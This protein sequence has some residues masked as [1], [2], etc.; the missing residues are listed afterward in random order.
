MKKF[1][2]AR[3]VSSHEPPITELSQPQ[4]Q[5]LEKQIFTKSLKRLQLKEAIQPSTMLPH[6]ELDVALRH[7]DAPK[8]QQLM[9]NQILADNQHLFPQD[10]PI[11]KTLGKKI[12]LMW[13][14]GIAN[15]HPAAPLLHSYSNVGCPVDCGEN[16][17]K[18]QIEAAI[19]RGPH[20]SAKHPIARKCLIAEAKEKEKG[21]Y[22]TIVKYGNIKHSLPPE[23]KISPIAMIP[24]KSRLFRCILDLSFVLNSRETSAN[25]VNATTTKLAPQKSMAE[26]GH[27][28]S[29]IIHTMATSYKYQLPFMFCKVDIKDGFWRMVVSK[30][31]AWNF[32]YIIPPSTENY[33]IDEIDI[34]VPHS[35]QMGWTDSPPF[36]C[37]ATETT[38]DIIEWLI[39]SPTPLPQHPLEHH[40]L[41]PP[42]TDIP[43]PTTPSHANQT[44][45][46]QPTDN[47]MPTPQPTDNPKPPNHLLSL[48]EV[49]MDD[50]LGCTNNL[51][52]Q[53]LQELTRAILHG[54]HTIFPPPDVSGHTGED[55]ISVKKLISEGWWA[56]EKDILGWLLNGST[57]TIHLPPQKSKKIIKLLKHTLKKASTPLQKF[58]ELVG[59]LIHASYGIPM[60]KGL[61]S[62]AYQAMRNDPATIILSPYLKQCL[63]DWI[64]LLH[65]ISSRPTHVIELITKPPQFI[66]YVD[67]CKFGAGGVWFSGTATITPTVWRVIFPPIIIARLINENNPKG[68]ITNSDLEMAGLLL[69]WLVLEN[70]AP[71]SLKYICAG[72]FSDNTPTVSWT[73]K[74]S[75]TNS[76]IGSYLVRALAIRMHVHHASALCTHEAGTDNIMADETS[77]SSRLAS[78]TN[79]SSP[80]IDVFN[81]KFPLP[82]A[83]CWQEYHLPPRLLSLVTSCL[84]GNPLPMEQWTKLKNEGKNIGK[85]G[86]VTADPGATLPSSKTPTPCTATSSSQPSLLGSGRATT[87]KERMCKLVASQKRSAPSQRQQNWLGNK[88]QST[89][90]TKLTP[91]Q[92]HG[93]WRV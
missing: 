70:I 53:H 72:M 12:G 66:G 75:S 61:L 26:L 52:P 84:L 38:R 80:F 47:P 58:Q 81:K 62:P 1:K 2:H 9:I 51:H 17:T 77:R 14:R 24:H 23:M 13:P 76:T 82:Q 63:K 32:C 74:L 73:T 33:D 39:A 6:T 65:R 29:R 45:T 46:T 85:T 22:A 4:R 60:G 67:A 35:L 88:A 34:V 55:P 28:L 16:W 30:A 91:S 64:T 31:A 83:Q 93:S 40:M 41:T 37:A 11:A 15:L 3:Y 8:Q 19:R 25:S 78:Y 43:M 90:H 54:I 44:P 79:T 36:F 5:Q 7:Q 50:F 86:P 18:A 71:R 69:E 89:K 27:V 68:T 57:F 92:W 21:G 49:Y 59:N 56:L 48:V 10:I 42:P 87:V 20:V